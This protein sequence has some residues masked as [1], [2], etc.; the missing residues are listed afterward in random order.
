MKMGRRLRCSSVTYRFRYALPHGCAALDR[1][2]S[3]GVSV[4]PRRPRAGRARPVCEGNSRAAFTD[5][6]EAAGKDR[7]GAVSDR[8]WRCR[9]SPPLPDGT[10]GAL[11][12]RPVPARR[13]RGIGS[14]SYPGEALRPRARLRHGSLPS[15]VSSEP[16]FAGRICSSVASQVSALLFS[17]EAGQLSGH[18]LS[19]EQLGARVFTPKRLA[20]LE[21]LASQAAISLDH[22]RL[23]A[24]L[25]RLNAELT[26]EK[27]RPKEGRRI[28]GCARLSAGTG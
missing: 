22:A 5:R 6:D 20:M 8:R 4:L 24:D 18:P 26:Q 2:G 11:P 25:G 1:F 27:Q 12:H 9:R 17:G 16:V 19:G 28:S 21:M 10:G 13:S 14:A 15:T 3:D 23:Y 7:R